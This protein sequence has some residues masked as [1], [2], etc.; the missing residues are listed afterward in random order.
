MTKNPPSS[1][2]ALFPAGTIPV[3]V[4]D[5]CV[6]FRIVDTD[7]LLSLGEYGLIRPVWSPTIEEEWVRNLSRKRPLLAAAIEERARAMNRAFPTATVSTSPTSAV[8]HTA[9]GHTH[10]KDIHVVATA[11]ASSADAVVT[12]NRS[13]FDQGTLAAHGL[14]IVAPD[15]VAEWLLRFEDRPRTCAALRA[16]RLR[17][18]NPAQRPR[19]FIQTLE[20]NGFPKTTRLLVP[21]D[22]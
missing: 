9:A 21:G 16:Q 13:D 14:I 6:L 7:T 2:G 19:V 4:L 12:H 20:D 5:A 10:K 8:P 11:F 1:T 3:L 17:K 15:D 18:K 22:L